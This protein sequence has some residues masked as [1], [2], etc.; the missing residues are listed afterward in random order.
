MYRI[1]YKYVSR[2]NFASPHRNLGYYWIVQVRFCWLWFRVWDVPASNTKDSVIAEL[3]HYLV[4]QIL[5]KEKQ[6]DITYVK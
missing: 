3:Q 6:K 1:I 4:E 5:I 2:D